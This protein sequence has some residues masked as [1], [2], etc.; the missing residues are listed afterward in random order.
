MGV[1][2]EQEGAAALDVDESARR[3]PGDDLGAP[4]DRDPEEAEPV[5]E[6]RADG[7]L[8]RRLDDPEAQPRRRDPLQIL[9]VG[10]EGERLLDRDG[11]DLGSFEDV[12]GHAAAR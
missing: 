10:E 3:L 6:A 9:R 4:A 1:L 11:N 7:E 12:V 2:P 5:A 8:V